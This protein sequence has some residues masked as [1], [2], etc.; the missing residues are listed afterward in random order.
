VK[1]IFSRHGES[2][3]NVLRVISNRDLPHPLTERGRIQAQALAERLAKRRILALYASPVLRA[4]QTA[5]MVGGKLSLSI[6]TAEA[7][8]EFDC[9]VM[10]GR[11]D[12]EAWQAHHEVIEACLGICFRHRPNSHA[13]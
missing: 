6:H 12:A 2:E 1:L 11:G 10:E 8:R 3:A 13:R 4:Q 5:L 9:G 7:L